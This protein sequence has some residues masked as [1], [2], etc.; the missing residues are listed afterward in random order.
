MAVND[1]NELVIHV[2]RKPVTGSNVHVHDLMSDAL[3]TSR[4][5]VTGPRPTGFKE[6]LTALEHT[7]TPHILVVNPAYSQE[8]PTHKTSSDTPTHKIASYTSSYN[9]THKTFSD[10]PSHKTASYSPAH[11]TQ[12]DPQTYPIL[13][14]RVLSLYKV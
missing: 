6:F 3:A 14:S 10:T 11:V 8:A 13:R 4:S 2:H 1:S 5:R 12:D 9:P 7:N